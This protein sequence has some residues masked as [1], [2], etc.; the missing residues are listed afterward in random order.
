MDLEVFGKNEKCVNCSLEKISQKKINQENTKKT[1]LP[2]ERIYIFYLS[3]VQSSSLVG[4]KYWILDIDEST[5]FKWCRFIKDKSL[6]I[7]NLCDILKEIIISG[8]KVRYLI[9]DNEG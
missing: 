4:N 2:G 5:R 8:K 1:T 7:P 3:S 9:C 6:L